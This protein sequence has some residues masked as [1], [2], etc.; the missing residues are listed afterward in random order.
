M[1]AL[2]QII[3]LASPAASL[4]RGIRL[5]ERGEWSNAFKFFSR[6]ASSGIVEAE[7]RVGR[8]YFEGAGVPASRVEA[9]RWLKRASLHGS[10]DAQV[11]LSVL[12][13]QGLAI[14]HDEQRPFGQDADLFETDAAARPDFISAKKWAR[15]AADTQSRRLG[16]PCWDT[17]SH[18]GRSS[19]VTSKSLMVR[20]VRECR[21]RTR[22]SW[23]MPCR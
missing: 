16:K 8:C 20:A 13:I 5:S 22:A 4:R 19:F 2:S 11:F 7:Y 21:F 15:M 9:T 12:F 1:N 23:G 17:C 3:V 18:A 6:A 14:D 10:V